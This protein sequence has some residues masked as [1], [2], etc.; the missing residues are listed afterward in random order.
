M[1]LFSCHVSCSSASQWNVFRF[2]SEMSDDHHLC[3][4]SHE[5]SEL[6]GWTL[7]SASASMMIMM[8]Y[9]YFSCF[10]IIRRKTS[11]IHKEVAV[12]VILLLLENY[13]F[14]YLIRSNN[15]LDREMVINLLDMSR[16]W[17]S[18]SCRCSW[19]GQGTSWCRRTLIC[20][21]RFQSC[22][23]RLEEGIPGLPLVMVKWRK[24]IKVKTYCQVK[25]LSLQ[26]TFRQISCD[27]WA[28]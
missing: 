2:G 8:K 5:Q 20:F 18:S 1:T 27:A 23:R 19:E 13:I 28:A 22:S 4:S 26:E 14:P 15:S 6:S 12:Q 16:C 24:H 7:C 10:V 9:I 25:L 11:F 3:F 21:S 17:R